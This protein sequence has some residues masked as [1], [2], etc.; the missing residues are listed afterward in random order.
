METSLFGLYLKWN[1]LLGAAC[2][3]WVF[4]RK[5]ANVSGLALTH[6]QQL[7][8]ARWL[9]ASLFLLV[10]FVPAI[11]AV[12]TFP[13]TLVAGE[14]LIGSNIDQGLAYTLNLGQDSFTLSGAVFLFL[15]AGLI[16]QGCRLLRQVSYLRHILEQSTEWK[17][18]GRV[19]VLFSPTVATPFSTKALG[20]CQVVLPVNLMKAPRHLRLVVKHELQ[21]LRNGDLDWVL[22]VEAIKL[23]CFWNPAIH[24][25]RNEFECLQEFACDEALLEE[26]R[27]SAKAYG[28]CLLDVASAGPGTTLIAASNMVPRFSLL[29]PHH[30]QLERRIHMLG[31]YRT[32]PPSIL[33]SLSHVMLAG[34]GSMFAFMLVFGAEAQGPRPLPEDKL[35]EYTYLPAS[36][37]PPRYPGRALDEKLEGWVQVNFAVNPEGK[38]ENAEVIDGCVSRAQSSCMPDEDVFN[39]NSLAAIQEFTFEPRMVDG[40]PVA[41]TG[42]QYVFRFSLG[43]EE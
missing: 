42:V 35:S 43:E 31:N 39:A 5:C 4:T 10:P 9:F 18:L 22:L 34:G 26:G 28:H 21:H 15:L 17:H 8:F 29:M 37:T 3:L 25:W 38:V 27:V 20:A 32:T 7:R 24:L 33:K 41:T 14:M 6:Q 40:V 11:Q 2:L 23:L 1:L 19:Q 30:S 13:T 12:V 16:V 36:T